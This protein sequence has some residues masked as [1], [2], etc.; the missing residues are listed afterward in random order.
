MLS[1]SFIIY[2]QIDKEKKVTVIT[3]SE[4]IEKR[5]GSDGSVETIVTT[6]SHD[7]PISD[8][9]I[10][11]MMKDEGDYKS[12]LTLNIENINGKET[13]VYKLNT[14]KD[15][16]KEELIWDG[17]GEPP[18][19]IKE[20]LKDV[21]IQTSVKGEEE[22]GQ[23]TKKIIVRKRDDIDPDD[24]NNIN[25]IDTISIFDIEDFNRKDK[26]KKVI[27][28]NLEINDDTSENRRGKR[29]MFL[30]DNEKE[31]GDIEP[32]VKMGIIMDDQGNGVKVESI[33]K[34]SPADKGGIEEKDI[35]LKID[36]TYIFSS[37]GL[38]KKMNSLKEGQNITVTVLRDGKEKKLSLKLLS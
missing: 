2:G 8:E 21:D 27:V 11:K 9:E 34:N 15:G 23:I 19:A 16:K 37:K 6:T 17:Q 33:I 22:K 14:F 5:I 4:N 20:K 32:R 18:A 24:M 31:G 30:R 7:A 35:I 36:D 3:K 13:K 10:Q 26:D 1:F 28:R 29:K 25:Q 38:L 12:Y